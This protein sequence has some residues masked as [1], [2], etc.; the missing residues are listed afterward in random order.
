[1][2]KIFIELKIIALTL[3][4]TI[5]TGC[6]KSKN[7]TEFI[8]RTQGRYLYNSDEIV[9]V[10][11]KDKEL[12]LIWRGAK[13]IKP[14]KVNDSTF[15]VKEMNEKIIFTSNQVD[16]NRYIS[17]LPKDNNKPLRFDYKKLEDSVKVPYE[18]LTNNEFKKALKGYLAIK[19]K[20][21]L[22]KAIDESGLNSVGY[23]ALRDKNFEKAI[24]IFK[25]NLALYP[26][27]SNVYDSLGEAYMKSGD[28]TLAIVNY[29]KALQL[30]SGNSRAKRLLKRLT[31]KE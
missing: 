21:S 12:Y 4:L 31:K 20:D 10:F 27:S 3:L 2:K 26:E 28:T 23:R 14:L 8:V 17:I 19:E 11:F 1:M 30:D 16:K 15:F 29:K 5:S 22:D 7:S 13:N 25:I 6:S 9:Q 24:N 18:Y